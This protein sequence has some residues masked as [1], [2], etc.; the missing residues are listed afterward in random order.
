[1]PQLWYNGHYNQS[2]LQRLKIMANEQKPQ[3]SIL[4][5][6]AGEKAASVVNLLYN[7]MQMNMCLGLANTI[8]LGLTGP[9][10]KMELGQL[11]NVSPTALG[12]KPALSAMNPN[13]MSAP[14]L[15]SPSK[16]FG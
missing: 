10:N 3:G 9:V 13:M 1:M 8:G 12:I 11:G 16:I 6:V 4:E 7:V 14:K 2:V 15:P 5:G